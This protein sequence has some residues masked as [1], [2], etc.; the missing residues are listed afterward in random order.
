MQIISNDKT[1]GSFTVQDI[2]DYN[3]QTLPTQPK[4]REQLVFLLPANKKAPDLKG[5][6]E[7]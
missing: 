5:D 6:D 2:K 4:I 1:V 3:P 7:V